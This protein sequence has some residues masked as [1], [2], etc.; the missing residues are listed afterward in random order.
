VHAVSEIRSEESSQRATAPPI[1]MP[2]TL[3]ATV[4]VKTSQIGSELPKRG[5][6]ILFVIFFD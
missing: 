6:R 2:G 3:K 1:G 4:N 5:I